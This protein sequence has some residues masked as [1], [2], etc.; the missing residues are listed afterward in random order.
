M[1]DVDIHELCL[2]LPG[3]TRFEAHE[4]AERIA[5]RLVATLP[6][7]R[8]GDIAELSTVHV[9]LPYGV[10]KDDIVEHVAAEIATALR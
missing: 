5:R 10:R 6:N 9:S 3:V 7:W 8:A 4:I 1:R 2:R